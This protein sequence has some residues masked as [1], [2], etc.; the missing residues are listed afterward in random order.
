MSELEAGLE[1]E[2]PE[3]PCLGGCG[4]AVRAIEL[5]GSVFAQMC[6]ECREASDAKDAATERAERVGR[7]MGLVRMGPRVQAWSL[8]SYPRDKVGRR[9]VEAALE[10]LA[11]FRAGSRAGL[12]IFGPVGSGK[13]GL[14]WALARELI[15]A[16][17]VE[18][19]VVNFRD[20]LAEIRDSFDQRGRRD[21]WVRRV[22]VL[23]LDDL[24]AER[25]TDWARDELATILE[26]R[27]QREL[28]TGFTSN[29]DPAALA[30]RLG[31]DD[32]VV[33][34]RLLSRLT[35]GAVQI[36]VEGTDRRT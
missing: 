34:E 22:P 9:A 19:N 20:L 18:A 30:K 21:L 1:A 28:V 7:L 14:A 24:G 6:P 27:Y 35:D 33:G 15:E 17:L 13:T 25:A 10:W 8:A 16:D 32:P 4:K 29:Y 11:A 31:H 36:R 12:L 26:W 2:F 5:Y 23:F 3:R